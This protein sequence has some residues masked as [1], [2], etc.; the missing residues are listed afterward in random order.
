[1]SSVQ[2]PPE[3]LEQARAEVR[4]LSD[5]LRQTRADLHRLGVADQNRALIYAAISGAVGIAVGFGLGMNF[6]IRIKHDGSKATS[7]SYAV[8]CL[9]TPPHS[10]RSS[11]PRSTSSPSASTPGSASSISSATPG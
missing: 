10:R 9:E 3:A 4:T 2:T 1:M 11:A 6:R 8:I 7:T 5:Q